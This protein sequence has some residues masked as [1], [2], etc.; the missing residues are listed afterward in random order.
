MKNQPESISRPART[1]ETPAPFEI[2]PACFCSF[3]KAC[4]F[5]I[6][7][8]T[9]CTFTVEV[10]FRP[11]GTEILYSSGGPNGA[12]FSESVELKNIGSIGV[13]L[14]PPTMISF[15]SQM[16]F[17]K[18]RPRVLRILVKKDFSFLNSI[19]SHFVQTT[20][21]PDSVFANF[22]FVGCGAGTDFI[23]PEAISSTSR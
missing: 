23:L 18:R 11:P 13:T 17:L 9:N 7:S 16:C 8:S 4:H 21:V 14:S 22:R 10:L 2:P 6:G 12:A 5:S 1:M 3:D 15:P 19:R 20:I